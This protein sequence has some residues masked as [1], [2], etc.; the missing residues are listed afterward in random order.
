MADNADALVSQLSDTATDGE[1]AA[2]GRPPRCGGDNLRE[3]RQARGRKI[4]DAT[5]AAK[6]DA[7]TPSND[8]NHLTD[9]VNDKPLV[10]LA[11]ARSGETG[12]FYLDKDG[13]PLSEPDDIIANNQ[14]ASDLIWTAGIVRGDSP[15]VIAEAVE[16]YVS[17]VQA[18]QNGTIS[19]RALTTRLEA[20]TEGSPF[21]V[22]HHPSGTARITW[23]PEVGADV[24]ARA[25]ATPRS[26]G[27]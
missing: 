10:K 9:R 15:D 25:R 21:I 7:L 16:E 27:T 8:D 26:L 3:A 19:E 23:D 5:A 12:V 18:W 17:A 13:K 20:A 22:T 1:R 2:P 4:S 24:Q 14:R 6:V 11:E